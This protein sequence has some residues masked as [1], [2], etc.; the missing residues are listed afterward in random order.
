MTRI[1]LVRHGETPWT[2]DGRVQG[3][4]A[5]PLTERGVDQARAAGSYIATAFERV[6]RIVTSDVARASE[7]A[8]HL[9]DRLPHS[10]A[11]ERDDAWRERNVGV[12]QGF[13]HERFHEAYLSRTD[14]GD[15]AAAVHTPEGGESWRAV[16]SRV[17]DRWAEFERDRPDETVVVVT[18]TGPIWC[19]L[20]AVEGGTVL[21]KYDQY[22]LH[23]GSVTEIAL[24]DAGAD[25]VR[26]NVDPVGGG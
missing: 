8:T 6:D 16:E 20:T 2:R 15:V 24:T 23:E 12:Y 18:H 17:L 21:D 19:V 14:W 25:I 4:A 11:V 26:L 9:R 22:D 5:V 3:W 10:P 1:V 7:S 13:S